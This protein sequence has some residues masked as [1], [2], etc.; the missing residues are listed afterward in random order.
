MDTR[1]LAIATLAALCLAPLAQAKTLYKWT[2]AQGTVQYSDSAPKNFRGPVTVIDTRVSQTPVISIQPSPAAPIQS[3]AV[4]PAPDFL[5][6]RRATRDAL[7]AR[8]NLA[9]EN[10][11]KARAALET[12]AD[13]DTG[14]GTGG[15]VI[16]QPQYKDTPPVG[17][18]GQQGGMH[19]MTQQRSNCRTVTG[20]N[21]KASQVCGALVLNED[22]INRRAQLEEQVK[23]AEQEVHDAEQAYRRGVD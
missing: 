15:Q 6:Q 19:G 10:L 17:Q 8:L 5:T 18:L 11:D 3:A 9:R 14:T 21:G 7:E 23:L 13:A 1:R 12:P 16:Q 22:T 20:A 2:D 4:A